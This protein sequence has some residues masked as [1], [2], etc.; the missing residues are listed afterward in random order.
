MSEEERKDYWSFPF[1]FMSQPQGDKKTII[2]I[3]PF[4]AC[5][6]TAWQDPKE[7]NV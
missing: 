7:N 4:E 5:A 2:Q 3:P 1:L 6:L